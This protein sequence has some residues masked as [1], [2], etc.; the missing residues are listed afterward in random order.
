MKTTKWIKTLLAMVSI[1]LVSGSAHATIFSVG[2]S[3][4]NLIGNAENLT[5][6][7]APTSVAPFSLGAGG[8]KFFTY[9]RLYTN[10]FGL[11]RNDLNDNDDSFKAN[12][13][14]SPP[15]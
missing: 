3:F 13:T 12:V 4:S 15:N 11:D 10:D 5:W 7:V 14:I 8:F 6:S 2:S 1:L 9:G